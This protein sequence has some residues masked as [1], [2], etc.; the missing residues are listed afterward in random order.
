MRR[1]LVLASLVLALAACSGGSRN[2]EQEGGDS[3]EAG[4]ISNE[5]AV[6][7]DASAP[8]MQEAR[9]AAGPDISPTAAPGVAFNYRYAFRLA[10]ERIA[11]VQERH[12]A[13]CEQ[14]GP[15]R[16]RIV[17]LQFTR[18]DDENIQARL[19]FKLEPS[20]ARTFGREGVAQVI[21][22][23]GMLVESEI[24]GTDVAPTIRQAG[25][26][27]AELRA[28]LARIEARLAGRLSSGDRSDLDYQ[29][30]QLRSQIRA[31][32][33]NRDAAEETLATTPMTFIYGAGRYVP[34]PQPR[35]A[36][37]KTLED[38]WDNFLDGVS[39]LFV[40]LVTV[41][42]W[43]LLALLGW[44]AFSRLRRRFAPR[45]APPEPEAS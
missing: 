3:G 43:V 7:V 35:R 40:I 1:S 34:G 15:A 29:A 39:I 27:I 9:S 19:S 22:A 8:A 42:P 20:I 2:G 26:S 14:L 38:A 12:A 44:F 23:D 32:E 18:H 31:V 10:A 28:E 16:C 5:A 24:S 36:F 4:T 30:Q 37:G 6:D 11:E 17:A 41:L 21:E 13:R 33:Q 45:P 25:R